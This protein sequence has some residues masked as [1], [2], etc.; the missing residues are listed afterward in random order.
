MIHA[1]V[2]VSVKPQMLEKA[3]AVYRDFVPAVFANE[4]GCLEY[5]PMVDHDMGLGN[6]RTDPNMIVVIER[7]KSIADF[8]AH[9]DG[10]PHCRSNSEKT[11]T[12][13]A[14]S[15]TIKVMHDAI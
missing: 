7:W 10:P 6:Q 2:F 8:R 13:Y 12:K 4:P 14:D 11:I 3:L 9:A 15:V 5:R 1:I